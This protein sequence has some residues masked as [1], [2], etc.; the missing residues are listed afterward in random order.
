MRLVIVTLLLFFST[1]L[2]A[3]T[4]FTVQHDTVNATLGIGPGVTVE[5]GVSAVTDTVIIVWKVVASDFPADWINVG[6]ICDNR[7]CV[8]TTTLWSPTS[9]TGATEISHAYGVAHTDTPGGDFH[10]LIGFSDTSSLGCHYLTVRM[11][12]QLVPADTATET[13]IICNSPLG[14]TTASR[15]KDDIILYPNPVHDE[16]H[17]FCNAAADIKKLTLYNAAGNVSGVYNVTGNNTSL[18]IGELPPGLYF[19]L[20]TD[21]K[22]AVIATKKFTKK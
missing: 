2:Y 6:A 21:S 18:H 3:Q 17:L 11:H 16:I 19:S 22:G 9:G 7:A 12:N 8:F 10:M 14:V 13:Y 20:L 15:S 1:G 5:D 4:T